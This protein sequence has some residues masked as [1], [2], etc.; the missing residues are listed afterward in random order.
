MLATLALSSMGVC[1]GVNIGEM[2]DERSSFNEISSSD[3]KSALKWRREKNCLVKMLQCRI[4]RTTR[5]HFLKLSVQ[6]KGKQTNRKVSNKTEQERCNSTNK[7]ISMCPVS[8]TCFVQIFYSCV[9]TQIQEWRTKKIEKEREKKKTMLQTHKKTQ[10]TK[11]K[12]VMR[13]S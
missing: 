12:T 10:E 13:V 9:R 6:R 5:V 2:L 3:G 8:C 7:F 1:G 4:D 11:T